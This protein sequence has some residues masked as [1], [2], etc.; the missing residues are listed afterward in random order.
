MARDET[1]DANSLACAAASAKSRPWSFSHAA[2]QTI[3]RAASISVAMS[4]TMK[5]TPSNVPIGAPE[6]LARLRVRDRRVERRLGEADGER[7]DRDP[8]AVE[9]LEEDPKAAAA[10]AE[11]VRGRHA[12][13]LEEQLAGRRRVQPQLLL[14]PADGEAGRVGRH[15]ECADLGLAAA[16]APVRAVTM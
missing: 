16:A 8:A 2:R 9:D 11:H 3:W 13:V 4:A 5:A 7:A 10:L 15:D 6:L 14:E 1:S 12:A